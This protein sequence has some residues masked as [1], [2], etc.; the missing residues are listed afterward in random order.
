MN[1]EEILKELDRA[2][3]SLFYV[4]MIDRWTEEDKEDYDRYSKRIRELKEML[5]ECDK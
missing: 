1:R 3:E 2:E 4:N 5:K